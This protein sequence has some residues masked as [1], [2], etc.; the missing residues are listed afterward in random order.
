[1]TPSISNS[2][3]T[4]RSK[5][6]GKKKFRLLHRRDALFKAVATFPTVYMPLLIKYLPKQWL[7][8]LDLQQAY[9][10]NTNTVDGQLR[11]R[12]ADLAIAIP[13]LDG[14]ATYLV[15]LEQQT[16][17]SFLPQRALDYQTRFI[18]AIRKEKGDSHP[19]VVYTLV[20]FSNHMPDTQTTDLFTGL[21]NEDKKMAKQ[22]LGAIHPVELG[23]IPE[24]EL[25]D[26]SACGVLET[27]LRHNRGTRMVPTL[28]RLSPT[29]KRIKKEPN[30]PEFMEAIINYCLPAALENERENMLKLVQDLGNEERE[31]AMTVAAALKREGRQEGLEEGRQEGLQE[32]RQEGL[33]EAA[34]GMLRKGIKAKDVIEITHLSRKRIHELLAKLRDKADKSR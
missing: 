27:L 33:E 1:M 23:K 2:K 13:F 4:S 7:N 20:L 11:E 30:G 28:E 8:K 16:T 21:N 18:K 22:Y 34:T 3:Q 24:E 19:F 15:L 10:L 9:L 26:G 17:G 6:I 14:K 12:I 29:L 31:I 5:K 25:N 32:G